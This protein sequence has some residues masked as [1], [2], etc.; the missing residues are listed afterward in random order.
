MHSIREI[1]WKYN[2]RFFKN[3][4]EAITFASGDLNGLDFCFHNEVWN[5]IKWSEPKESW[6]ELCTE[7]AKQIRKKYDYV[8]L[9]YS[10]GADSQ[11]V[12]DIFVNNDIFIDE[13]CCHLVSPID[14]FTGIG[15]IEQ[16]AIALPYMEILKNKLPKTKF[17]INYL[18][19]QHYDILNQENWFFTQPDISFILDQPDNV[20]KSVIEYQRTN[21]ND[22]LCDLQGGDKSTITC[23]D[24]EYYT[25]FVDDKIIPT[26]N[27]PFVEHFFISPDFTELYV[28]QTHKLV[29]YINRQD[30][31]RLC[32]DIKSIEQKAGVRSALLIPLDVGKGSQVMSP[33]SVFLQEQAKQGNKVAYDLYQDHFKSLEHIDKSCFNNQKIKDG[34]IGCVTEK[35]HLQL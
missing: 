13:I 2:N 3:K 24:G 31:V 12:L 21:L 25:Y 30:S 10:A 35:Y 29:G 27:S 16:N 28:K 17:T 15:N 8:R 11:T 20:Y 7:R 34:L 9:W 23:V 26:V 19:Q 32:D 33:K 22:K 1:G 5:N 18:G 6:S 14:E 4:Y